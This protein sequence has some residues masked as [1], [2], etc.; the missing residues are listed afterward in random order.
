[1][2]GLLGGGRG[3]GGPAPRWRR[4][5]PARSAVTLRG[6]EARRGGRA[7]ARGERCRGPGGRWYRSGGR[8]ESPRS[9]GPRRAPRALPH[10]KWKLLRRGGGRGEAGPGSAHWRQRGLRQWRAQSGAPMGTGGRDGTG[11]DRT[12]SGRG[13]AERIGPGGVSPGEVCPP[14][15]LS[16]LGSVLVESV[17]REVCPGG[18][19]PRG[20]C[21]PWDLPQG[22]RVPQVG[23]HPRRDPPPGSGAVRGMRCSSGT[24]QPPPAQSPLPACPA[25]AGG[26]E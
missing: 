12:G 22:V 23:V 11:R 14:W 15:G 2:A 21:P 16:R 25:G 10:L 18:V 26:D 20:V 24:A 6:G 4:G 13:T 3:G 9:L 8:P 1:M 7:A 5:R 19:R 17:P